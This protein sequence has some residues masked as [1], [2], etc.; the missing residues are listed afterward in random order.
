MITNLAAGAVVAIVGMGSAY[1]V[2]RLHGAEEPNKQ[3]A[4]YKGNLENLQRKYDKANRTVENLVVELL[5]KPLPEA[6]RVKETIKYVRVKEPADRQC[7]SDDTVRMLNNIRSGR[8]PVDGEDP[9]DGTGALK[10]LT[11]DRARSALGNVKSGGGSLD[12]G[13][14]STRL[15]VAPTLQRTR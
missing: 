2:G 7:L 8:P 13:S 5:E 12:G 4:V 9:A 14:D 10:G 1:Y 6:P 11:P 3:L 15:I